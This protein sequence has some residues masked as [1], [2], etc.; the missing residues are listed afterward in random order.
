MNGAG[1]T[2][3]VAD[4]SVIVTPAIT[5]FT[6]TFGG[7]GKEVTITG[8]GFTG[9]TAVKFGPATASF[10]FDSDTQLTATVPATAKTG[11]ITVTNAAG[12]A[13]STDVFTVA[14]TP[15]TVTNFSPALGAAGASVTI[16]GTNLSSTTEV[17]FGGVSASFVVNSATSVTA[18]VPTVAADRRRD[19][20]QADGHDR[21]R[22]D[23]D[24][25]DVPGHRG[26][27]DHVVHA[28]ER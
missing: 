12:S 10:T 1:S 7:T 24:D 17:D 23:D 9:T 5:S 6:P 27:V 21:R 4:F 19:E 20:R 14:T 8:T 15:P 22:R 11:A 2:D 13:V 16:T 3:S 25:E 18:T 28:W 26:A